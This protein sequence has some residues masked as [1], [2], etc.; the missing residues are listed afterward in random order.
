MGRRSSVWRTRSPAEALLGVDRPH[1][2]T[3]SSFHCLV[4]RQRQRPA[5]GS[6]RRNTPLERARRLRRAAR[7]SDRERTRLRK[8]ENGH[9][10]WAQRHEGGTKPL[11]SHADPPDSFELVNLPAA[12]AV[13]GSS[14]RAGSRNGRGLS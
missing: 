4:E 7:W 3:K 14:Q 9:E 10:E 2:I 13:S 11:I 5:G 6:A 8:C 12:P 1:F